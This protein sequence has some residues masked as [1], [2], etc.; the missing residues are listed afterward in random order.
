G[1]AFG[2]DPL[3]GDWDRGVVSAAVGL[4]EG[5]VSGM[6]D[7]DTFHVDFSTPGAQPR[8]SETLAQQEEALRLGA[9]GRGQRAPLDA[10]TG[11]GPP[12]LTHAEVRTIATTTRRLGDAFGAPQDIEW[13]LSSGDRRLFVLQARPITALAA[14]LPGER[15]VWDNSNI[16]ESYSGITSPLTFS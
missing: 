12:T 2:A 3:S 4:G 1:V 6:F 14:R 7:A 5:L 13:A 11:A 8:V 10:G 9:G 15:R 16:V